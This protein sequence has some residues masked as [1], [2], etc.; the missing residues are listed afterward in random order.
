M[1]NQAQKLLDSGLRFDE[2]TEKATAL[3]VRIFKSSEG[4][5]AAKKYEFKDGSELAIYEHGAACEVK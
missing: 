2:L 3:A 5:D 1:A 4:Y